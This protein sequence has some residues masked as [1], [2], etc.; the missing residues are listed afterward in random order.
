MKYKFFV[1]V[2]FLQECSMSI[3]IIIIIIIIII[4]WD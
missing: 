2:L 1:T 3:N 4:I